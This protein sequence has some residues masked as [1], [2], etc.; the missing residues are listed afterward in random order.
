MTITLILGTFAHS[1]PP[2]SQATITATELA[3]PRPTE[4]I[5][6][7]TNSHQRAFTESDRICMQIAELSIVA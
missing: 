7:A 3:V 1:S 4:P 6:A 2:P 5:S